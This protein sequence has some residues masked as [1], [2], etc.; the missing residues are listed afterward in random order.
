MGTLVLN[1]QRPAAPGDETQPRD[2]ADP[3]PREGV[4]APDEAP[5]LA[6]TASGIRGA[7]RFDLD[8]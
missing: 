7:A 5:L 6:E 2:R 1:L 4:A 3:D 8:L